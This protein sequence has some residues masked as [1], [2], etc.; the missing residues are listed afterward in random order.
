[1]ERGT[2]ESLLRQGGVYARLHQEF[3]SSSNSGV[4]ARGH[5]ES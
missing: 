1:V 4:V 5:G 3:V 2:H